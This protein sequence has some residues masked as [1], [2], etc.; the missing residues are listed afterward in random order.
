MNK[1]E[2][3]MM[4][5]SETPASNQNDNNGNDYDVS[6]R[7]L[8]SAADTPVVSVSVHIFARHI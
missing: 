1:F 5:M 2:M 4:K 8:Y 7:R 6:G 3:E